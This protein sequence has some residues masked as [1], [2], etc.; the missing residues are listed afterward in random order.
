MTDNRSRYQAGKTIKDTEYGVKFPDGTIQWYG[1]G[2]SNLGREE[3]R[4]VFLEQREQNLRSLGIKDPGVEFL[5][6]EKKTTFS[7]P[8]RIA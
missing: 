3:G 1:D 8:Q 6:R 7:A 5:S 4:K 2:F